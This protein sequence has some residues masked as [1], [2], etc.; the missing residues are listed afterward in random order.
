MSNTYDRAA[1][2]YDLDTR[3]VH[4]VDIAFFKEMA[5][6]K[7]V[8]ELACGTGRVSIPLVENGA[9]VHGLDLSP[10]MLQVFREK[11]ARLPEKVRQRITITEGNMANFSLGA[12]FPLIIIPFRSFQG[13]T[14]ESDIT[15]CL[16]CVKAHLAP[17][18]RFIVNCFRP[19]RDIHRRYPYPEEVMW[20][21]EGIVAKHRGDN[22]DTKRQMIWPTMI[23]ET[24]SERIEEPL[25]LRYY[26]PG[27]LKK[28]L[29]K[30][31]FKILE[32]HGDYDRGPIKRHGGE[33][34]Y[35]CEVAG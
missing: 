35:V 31:G 7:S 23:Y 8:L 4:H 1:W 3:E 26:Y 22:I 15:G 9:Q 27:Q 16:Q 33:Q 12:Q 14:E 29:R 20:E 34:I 28:L 17:G 21:R 13:L 2:I 24:G 32:Q 19:Y 18:G 6:N 30:A 10:S 25:A 5:G 11:L